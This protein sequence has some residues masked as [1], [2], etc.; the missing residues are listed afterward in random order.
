M[1]TLF[2]N[3]WVVTVDE[4]MRVLENASVRVQ[5]GRITYVGTEPQDETGARSAWWSRAGTS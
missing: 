3:V 4:Q 2:K 5:N 1:D